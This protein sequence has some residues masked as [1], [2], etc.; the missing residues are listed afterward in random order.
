MFICRRQRAKTS[1]GNRPVALTRRG[2]AV[3]PHVIFLASPFHF[4]Q[5]EERI[6]AMTK[7]KLIAGSVL[8][9]L[10]V[11]GIAPITL[12]QAGGPSDILVVS[13]T[14]SNDQGKP[15]KEVSL[16]FF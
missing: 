14:I 3:A 11:M 4:T 2:L 15:L 6:L 13:G 16:Q 8:I 10:M 9:W 7:T 1:R 12:A 5:N